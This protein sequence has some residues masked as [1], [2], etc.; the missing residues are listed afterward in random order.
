MVIHSKNHENNKKQINPTLKK[1]L[2]RTFAQV[3][4]DIKNKEEA[5][6]FIQD[7]FEETEIEVFTKRLAIAYWLKKGRSYSNIKQNLKASSAT[8]AD[9]SNIAKR[10]GFQLALKKIEAEEWAELWAKKIKKITGNK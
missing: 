5:I 3:I 4:A 6:D 1:E 7:F 10:K 2:V 9:I 8:I